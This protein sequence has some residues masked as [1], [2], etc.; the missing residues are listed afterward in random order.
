MTEDREYRVKVRVER[1]LIVSVRADS[2][3][4]AADYIDDLHTAVLEQAEAELGE[5][6][7][8]VVDVDV[9]EGE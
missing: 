3:D 7:V 9:A 8:V 4:Q 6:S 1:T 2:P 5:F